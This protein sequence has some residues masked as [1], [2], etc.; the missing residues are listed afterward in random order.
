M[1]EGKI[2]LARIPQVNG[3]AK[4]RPAVA[5]KTLPPFGDI[6][7][8][9]VSRQLHQI[10]QGFDEII[11]VNDDDFASS[12]LDSTSLIRLSFLSVVPTRSIPGSIGQISPDRHRRRLESLS[13]YLI[14]DINQ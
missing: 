4:L 14:N 7:M 2:I 1:M 9:G 5:L 6:L 11:S 10:V 8:C 13:K 3:A 12:G